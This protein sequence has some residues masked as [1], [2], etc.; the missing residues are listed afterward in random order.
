M[1]SAVC[2]FDSLKFFEFCVYQDSISSG[3]EIVL[4]QQEKISNMKMFQYA[5]GVKKPHKVAK[6]GFIRLGIKPDLNILD[7]CI[8]KRYLKYVKDTQHYA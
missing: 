4:L 5:E 6:M 3:T 7:L 2:H 8:F 1:E